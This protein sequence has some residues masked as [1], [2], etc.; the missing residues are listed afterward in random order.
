MLTLNAYGKEYPMTF[1]LATYAENDNLYVGLVT[2][3]AGY[4]ESWSDL[5]VCL[6]VDCKPNCAF[7]DVNLNG[8]EIMKWLE[9]NNLGVFTGNMTLS[10]WVLY[11][12]FEFNMDELM[13]HVTEDYR[14]GK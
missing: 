9:D 7:I 3:D 13:K 1:A 4:L 12:E 6:D 11:P 8:K 5:T 14:E 10:G 2:H